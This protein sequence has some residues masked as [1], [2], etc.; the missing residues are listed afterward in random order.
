MI[1]TGRLGSGSGVSMAAAYGQTPAGQRSSDKYRCVP[2]SPQNQRLAL[3]MRVALPGS[4]MRAWYDRSRR[5]PRTRNVSRMPM[6][7]QP[8]AEPPVLRQMA[9]K[10]NMNGTGVSESTVNSI[11]PHWQLP[12]SLLLRL[13]FG[14]GM[15]R[16]CGPHAG[17]VN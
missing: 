3:L 13:G 6:M 14:L 10:Q 15:P 2:H 9:Q 7:L 1:H 11:F 5:L 16:V 4:R 8:N 17:A 12:L